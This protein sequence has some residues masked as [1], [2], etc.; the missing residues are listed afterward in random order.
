VDIHLVKDDG[1]GEPGT[2]C[3][4]LNDKIS[5]MAALDY[6][7]VDGYGPENMSLELTAPSGS[8]KIYVKYFDA[9][10]V[11]GDVQATVR[12]YD[13]DNDLIGTYNHTFTIDDV[14]DDDLV[15]NPAKDWYVTEWVVSP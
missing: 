15:Y 8:Y 13:Q 5:G 4:W 10:P 11:S 7:D 2:H 1:W 6:D 12:V 14:S 9:Y 3:F